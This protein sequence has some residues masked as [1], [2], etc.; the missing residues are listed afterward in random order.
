MND[1]TSRDFAAHPRAAHPALAIGKILL[2]LESN[3]AHL[4]FLRL[5]DHDSLRRFFPMTIRTRMTLALLFL[6][7]LIFCGSAGFH[8][9]EGWTWFDGFYMTITTMSTVGYAEIHP[10]SHAGKLF[11]SFLIMASVLGGGF[12]IATFTQALLEFEFGKLFGRTRMQR[13]ISKLTGHYIV[14]GAGRVGRTVARELRARGQKCLIIERDAARAKWAEGEN[15]PVVIGNASSEENLNLA[16]ISRAEGLVT[17][18][19]SDAENLYIVLTARGLRADL[20]IIARA[21]EDDATSKFLRA[22]ASQVISPYSFVG[23]RIAQLLVSPNV[24]DFIDAA[25]G[26]ERLDVEISEVQ[27]QARSALSG[28]TIADSVIRQQA[29]VIVLGLKS[30]GGPMLFNPAPETAIQ[31]SDYL[32]VIGNDVQIKKLEALASAPA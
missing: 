7:G 23:H 24:L 6:G 4:D 29:G 26:A 5:P 28:K 18:V 2:Q 22:G 9:L 10:L 13:E 1:G 20:R 8:Y 17:A 14:C 21:S 30:P 11:N 16:Q 32:I 15:F 12:T 31:A 3:S 25:V 27:I 19:S